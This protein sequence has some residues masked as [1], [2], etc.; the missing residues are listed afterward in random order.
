[1]RLAGGSRVLAGKRILIVEDEPLIALDL[2][3]VVTDH[4]GIVVGPVGSIAQASLIAAT[5]PIDGAILDLRLGGELALS[6]A[7][8]LRARKIPFV[9]HSGQADT[10]LPRNWPA[11][12]VI[13]KPALPE[14]VIAL[15]AGVMSESR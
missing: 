5:E 3:T 12:P 9:I 10:T 7:E 14:A 8:R 15:L 13:S 2:E 4:E 6:V 11:V 1:M